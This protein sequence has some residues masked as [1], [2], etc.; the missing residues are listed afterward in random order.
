MNP[1]IKTKQ[2][3]KEPFYSNVLSISYYKNII[4]IGTINI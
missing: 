4:H 3:N 2:K 1:K